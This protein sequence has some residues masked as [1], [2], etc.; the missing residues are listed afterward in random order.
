MGDYFLERQI[1]NKAI[2]AEKI[3]KEIIYQVSDKIKQ[4]SL[5]LKSKIP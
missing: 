1:I 3:A 2:K 4:K 5:K